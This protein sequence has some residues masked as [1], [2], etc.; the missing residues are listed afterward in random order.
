M[1]DGAL[2]GLAV[3]GELLNVHD[4]AVLAVDGVHGRGLGILITEHDHARPTRADPRLVRQARDQSLAG[5]GHVLE[6]GVLVW[7]DSV[8]AG[9]ED[10]TPLAL[11]I[12]K[13]FLQGIRSAHHRGEPVWPELE[14]QRHVEVA[15]ACAADDL[16]RGGEHDITQRL[17]LGESFFGHARV[18]PVLF[19]AVRVHVLRGS[20]HELPRF[21]RVGVVRLQAG[22]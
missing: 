14:G 5:W 12:Q 11:R 18:R 19:V 8:T 17:Y 20:C 22:G 1:L 10:N 13:I 2:F 21:V 6:R 4:L 3:G 7:R 9:H 15:L 16:G